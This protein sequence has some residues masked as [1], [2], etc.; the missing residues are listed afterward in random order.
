MSH[1]QVMH[2][3]DDR[4]RPFN[5][6]HVPQVTKGPIRNV[7]VFGAPGVRITNKRLGSTDADGGAAGDE[8]L[9]R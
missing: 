2:A 8:Y 4:L 5:A 6:R 7:T 9:V 3:S 1:T